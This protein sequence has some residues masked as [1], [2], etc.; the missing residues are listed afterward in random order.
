MYSDKLLSPKIYSP[1]SSESKLNVVQR[2]VCSSVNTPHSSMLNSDVLSKEF[3]VDKKSHPMSCN[4]VNNSR[5][6]VCKSVQ[7]LQSMNNPFLEEAYSEMISGDFCF[8]WNDVTQETSNKYSRNV[9]TVYYGD[10]E[11]ID[12]KSTQSIFLEIFL[13]LWI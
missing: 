10:F 8:N 3:S 13:I 2:S 9:Q 7:T 1:I 11:E 4:H 5:S 6:V 12:V